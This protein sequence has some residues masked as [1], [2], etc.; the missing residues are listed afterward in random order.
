MEFLAAPKLEFLFNLSL[1]I[2]TPFL[3]GTTPIGTRR[4]VQVAG[5]V[6]E[7][8]KLKGSV[9]PGG[10]DWITVRPDG[11]VVQDVRIMLKTD[12]D[13]LIL[14]TYRGLRNGPESV[15]K[16]LD[17]NEQVD[18]SEYYFR[19]APIFETSS[20]KYDWLNQRLFVSTGK[21]AQGK[22]MYSVYVVC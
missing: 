8:P 3:P 20:E 22:V 10:D 18:P 21:R 11:S 2:N 5:G 13:E 15:M 7:G 6:F 14:M 1:D 12:E 17:Q 16:R 4:I 19:N 9:I